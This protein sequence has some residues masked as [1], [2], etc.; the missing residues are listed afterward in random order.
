MASVGQATRAGRPTARVAERPSRRADRSVQRSNAA[1]DWDEFDPDLY[2]KLNYQELH[3]DD[4]TILGQVGRFFERE[5][6]RSRGL[7]GIDVGAGANV[8]PTLTM[9]PYCESVTLFE[10]SSANRNWL[11]GQREHYSEIWNPYWDVL[12]T[13]ETYQAIDPRECFRQRMTVRY[14]D[15]FRPASRDRWGI[16]T[17]FFC[18]ESITQQ[19]REFYAA[20]DNF[21]GMLKPGAPFAAAFMR[22]SR[23]YRVAGIDFPA[24]SITPVDVEHRL[25]PL[26]DYLEVLPVV[27]SKPLRE[28]YKGMILALGR[29]Q[30][31]TRS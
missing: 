24:V 19:E 1:Y 5:A 21:I 30:R 11:V 15:V 10:R 6:S 20:L 25:E 23:G 27:S 16:G 14:G 2:V 29:K 12:A 26:V 18:A 13:R 31:R 9:L 7:Q 3:D 4:A 28:G 17:M 8:Y 22:E